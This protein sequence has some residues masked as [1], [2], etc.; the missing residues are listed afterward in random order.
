MGWSVGLYSST[1][2]SLAPPGP[3][4][5]TSLMSRWS[6]GQAGP[7]VLLDEELLELL[8]EALLALDEALEVLLAPPPEAL[9]DELA[10]PP[11]PPPL[12]DV[13]L[14]APPLPVS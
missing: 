14:V 5:R 13:V 9:L 4:V 12:E 2:S 3:R 6:I 10:A 8:D 7:P 11:A 1:K